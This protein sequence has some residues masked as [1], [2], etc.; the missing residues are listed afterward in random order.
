M[1]KEKN[2]LYLVHSGCETK[3][4]GN[5]VVRKQ[6]ILI[7]HSCGAWKCKI[8]VPAS[9]VCSL[10]AHVVDGAREL[11]G[12]CFRKG[13]NPFLRALRSGPNPLLEVPPPDTIA[14]GIRFPR[15]ESEGDTGIP[16]SA[17]FKVI[18]NQGH[19]QAC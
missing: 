13:M 6:R 1:K 12:V 3:N 15:G 10:C 19:F 18:S 5:R 11:S 7:S 16:I 4:T 8:R 14:V 17:I 2:Q 9:A